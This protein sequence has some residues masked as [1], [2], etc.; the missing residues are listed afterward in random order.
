MTTES[1]QRCSGER[2][3]DPR[4]LQPRLAVPAEAQGI[5]GVAT[6]NCDLLTNA[7]AV[8]IIHDGHGNACAVRAIHQTAGEI[9]ELTIRSRQIVVAAGTI[10]T[11][12]LLLASGIGNDWVGR[13]HHTHGGAAAVSL[14][15]PVRKTWSGPNHSVA[16]LDFVHAGEAPWGGGVIFDLPAT[17]PAAKAKAGRAF[18]SFGAAHKQWM[19]EAPNALGTMSM[20]QEIPHE[21]SRVSIDPA[22]RDRYGMPV[23]RLRGV[24]HPASAAAA[25]FMRERCVD[26]LIE[27]GGRDIQSHSFPGGSRGA[28]H[29]AGSVRMGHDPA[30]SACDARGK[31]HGTSNVYVADAS[32]HPTNGGFNPGLTAMACALRVA[33]LMS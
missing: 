23:A 13:S 4:A 1:A 11:P 7:Q 33:D 27:L 32:L 5:A 2:P 26:W 21:L 25:E 19:R 22:V 9:R 28:E 20:V 16:T 18:A 6:G 3:N 24:A 14:H 12:R 15:S 17:L 8:E 29:S 31:V 30:T 10:E